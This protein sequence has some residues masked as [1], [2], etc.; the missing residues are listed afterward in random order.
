MAV[1]VAGAHIALGNQGRAAVGQLLALE[2]DQQRQVGVAA[3]I[4]LEIGRAAALA[5]VELLEDD[6]AHG[7]GHGRVR[8]LLGVHPQVG[9]LGDLGVVGRDGHD[10]GALVADL[11]E[12]VGVGVRVWGT[13]EPQA[14]MKLELYQSALSGTSVCSPQVWGLAGGRSQYQS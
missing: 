10:L 11:G 14:M 1:E 9:Q 2:A 13:L 3:R 6:V 5:E 12:E 4:V 7:H 8:A